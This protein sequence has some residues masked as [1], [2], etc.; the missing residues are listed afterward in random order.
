MVVKQQ[1][2]EVDELDHEVVDE[3]FGEV[4]IAGLH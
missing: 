3:V 4:H 1:D 2:I